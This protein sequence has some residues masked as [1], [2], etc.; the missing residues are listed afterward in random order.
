M[1]VLSAPTLR[2]AV[3]RDAC[4]PDIKK[5]SRRD[6]IVADEPNI[7]RDEELFRAALTGGSSRT[8]QPPKA[9]DQVKLDMIWL[10]EKRLLKRWG[11]PYRAMI[12]ALTAGECAFC[13]IA[14][15]KTL[16]HSMPKSVHP[17]LAVEPS[18][19]VPS[20]RDCNLN[21][22]VGSKKC[23]ISPYADAWVE[24]VPWLAARIPD[25]S[26]PGQLEFFVAADLPITVDQREALDEM[27]DDAELGPRYALLASRA[28]ALSAR[29]VRRR[30]RGDLG[31]FAQSVMQEQAEDALDEFGANRWET[32]AYHAW[33]AVAPQLDWAATS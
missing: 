2:G 14:R 17:R 19:L 13:H 5:P 6:R 26:R 31:V 24:T 1:I 32:A 29:R 28:F 30:G 16:D 18:N 15:A 25:H 10:Y 23:S 3:I 27:F 11:A 22:G 33:A 12:M 20:C 8:L 4:V 7:L 9:T 21:R